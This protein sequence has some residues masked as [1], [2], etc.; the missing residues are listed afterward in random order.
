MIVVTPYASRRMYA[1]LVRGSYQVQ[2]YQRD[3]SNLDDDLICR[4]TQINPAHKGPNVPN[5]ASKLPRR[6]K[7]IGF[8]RRKS[9]DLRIVSFNDPTNLRAKFRNKE[10]RIFYNHDFREKLNIVYKKIVNQALFRYNSRDLCRYLLFGGWCPCFRKSMLRL[11]KRDYILNKG[12][13][14]LLKDMDVTSYIRRV[15]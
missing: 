5:I 2:R 12:I 13:D 1:D 11:S 15:H 6:S 8:G 3:N 14:K 10:N 7:T 4:E 9:D